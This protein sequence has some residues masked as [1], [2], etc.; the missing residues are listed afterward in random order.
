MT[1][2]LAVMLSHI[3][4]ADYLWM[5]L[6]VIIGACLQGA[7]GIGF[8]MF[9]GP[10]L[11]ITHPELVPGPVLLLSASLSLLSALREYHA[12]DFPALSYSLAGRLPASILAGMTFAVLPIR[13]MS[14]VFALL[15]LLGVW[16]SLRGWRVRA[17]PRNWFLAGAM[18]GFMGTITSVGAPPMALA[19]Q[20]FSEPQLRATLGVF[21]AVGC[22][23][24]LAA[25]AW[26]GRF[27]LTEF[28][29]GVSL[30]LPMMLGF[31]IS[32]TIVP[33]IKREQLRLLILAM[34]GCA[35][36][37]LLVLQLI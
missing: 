16:M 17:M 8:G 2:Q 5:A 4:T 15:I 32:N 9:V 10:V 37:V 6:V 1:H 29:T 35:A 31:A 23:M 34:S 3:L 18:S 21:F 24:S 36:V 22:V 33:H 7:G 19:Y 25:L 13:A 28:H 27:G 20:S 30:I 12:I 14:I 26:F 11:A